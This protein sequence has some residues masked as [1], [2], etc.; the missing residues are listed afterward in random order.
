[1]SICPHCFKELGEPIRKKICPNCQ[2]LSVVVNGA[3]IKATSAPF[4]KH[5]NNSDGDYYSKEK[6]DLLWKKWNKEIILA[7]NDK[8]NFITRFL[9]AYIKM[10]CI[11]AIEDRQW[12]EVYKL[13]CRHVYWMIPPY[14]GLD[15]DKEGIISRLTAPYLLELFE[16]AA[17]K[18]GLT[19][20]SKK[21]VFIETC[22]VEQ[23]IAKKLFDVKTLV[24]DAEEFYCY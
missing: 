18:A 7:L 20:A 9:T 22:K 17:T 21:E 10:A 11:L 24:P 15:S 19:E 6:A 14:S 4:L 8:Y 2:N 13:L 16:I 1:M 12:I 5:Y 23:K 3:W